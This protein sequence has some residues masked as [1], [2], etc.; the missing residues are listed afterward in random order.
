MRKRVHR[1]AHDHTYFPVDDARES[2]GTNPRYET[3][4]EVK[5]RDD[6]GKFFLKPPLAN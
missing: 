6:E 3:A 5:L 2:T 4:I 1:H